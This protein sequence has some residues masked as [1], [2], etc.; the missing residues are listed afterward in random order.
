M[1]G[2]GILKFIE[3]IQCKKNNASGFKLR[4]YSIGFSVT[5]LG[6]YTSGS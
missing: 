5:D 3:F 1:A 4:I 2:N 6:V